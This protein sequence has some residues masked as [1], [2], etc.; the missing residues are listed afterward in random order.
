MDNTRIKILGT[1]TPP[2]GEYVLYW[3]QGSVRVQDNLALVYARREATR[4]NV[5]LL[6]MFSL[7]PDYPGA[8]VRSMDFLLRGLRVV[9]EDLVDLGIAFVL[10]YGTPPRAAKVLAAKARSV[11]VDKSNIPLTEQ[12][13][14][15]LAKLVACP[16]I[17]VEDN[18]VI[19]VDEV[20]QKEEYSAATLRPK[21]T[22]LLPLYAR[23]DI[24]V[25]VPGA[26]KGPSAM[27]IE[28][29]AKGLLVEGSLS[30]LDP[31]QSA[32][33]LQDPLLTGRLDA[34]VPAVDL[35]SG[36]GAALEVLNRF[37][38]TKLSRYDEDRNNPTLD[39]QSG[40]SPYLHFGMISPLRVVQNALR[41][42]GPAL[43]V[44]LEEMVVRRELAVNF[45]LRSGAPDKYSSLPE[46]AKKTLADHAGD[47]R[48]HLYSLEDWEAARTHDAAWNAAQNQMKK[49]GKMHGYMRMY[50]GK[51]ILEWSATP[52]EAF[53]TAIYLNDRWSLDGRDPNGW[54]GVAWC[55]GK[56]DRP[57]AER[58]VFGLIRYMNE[59]GLRRKFD[60]DAYIAANQ[61]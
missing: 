13:R 39:G 47:P 32:G 11:V 46:W 30:W 40:L 38:E 25:V 18:V 44:F 34:E 2:A 14:R 15:D 22:R 4:L 49:T 27:M 56:H 59:A 23:S 12:W 21:I 31:K 37:L 24:P 5:P 50:W 6:V 20:S 16:V 33:L 26:S 55:F 9:W 41:Y 52:E 48:S 43:E 54:T 51:K 7:T 29:L 19:P 35:P 61:P 17:Q 1:Q 57:W 45:S 10:A 42:P 36:S 58:P 53:K 60:L 8:N 28:N 3:M